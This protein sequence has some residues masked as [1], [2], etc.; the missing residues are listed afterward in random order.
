VG[1]AV[2]HGAVVARR[3]HEEH[4]GLRVVLLAAARELRH[5]RK[6]SGEADRSAARQQ[7][8]PFDGG[9]DRMTEAL[10][11]DADASARSELG[12]LAL[13]TPSGTLDEG[14]GDRGALEQLHAPIHV[15]LIHARKAIRSVE[16][17]T[18]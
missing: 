6:I 3:A 16:R 13:E 10:V 11:D 2:E 14:A 8:L 15:A 1:G 12:E 18:D 5:A 7:L 17:Q 9:S 4:P